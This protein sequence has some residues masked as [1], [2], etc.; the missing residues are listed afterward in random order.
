M[1]FRTTGRGLDR[2][3]AL[4]QVFTNDASMQAQQ[5]IQTPS[6]KRRHKDQNVF[7]NP[8]LSLT[9]QRLY[10]PLCA[11]LWLYIHYS[12]LGFTCNHDNVV[13]V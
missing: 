11:R 7:S 2:N 9:S 13:C 8:V 10:G 6:P 3:F 4:N 12:K 1:S 5:S